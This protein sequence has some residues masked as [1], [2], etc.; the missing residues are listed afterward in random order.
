MRRL[1]TLTFRL[2][3]A[4]INVDQHAPLYATLWRSHRRYVMWDSNEVS[5]L[6]ILY[7]MMNIALAPLFVVLPILIVLPFGAY[8]AGEVAAQIEQEQRQNRLD[9]LA[10]LPLGRLHTHYT[11]SVLS[12]RRTG[13]YSRIEDALGMTA[14]ITGIMGFMLSV[15]VFIAFAEA[16]TLLANSTLQLINM[17]VTILGFLGGVYIQQIQSVVLAQLIG[18]IVPVVADFSV[19]ARV[20]AIVSYLSLQVALYIA[21][22]V[23]WLAVFP[24]ILRLPAL[25]MA[26]STVVT[27][28]LLLTADELILRGLWERLQTDLNAAPEASPL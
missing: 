11:L 9:L 17:L 2:W 28:G 5:G 18:L 19:G 12:I 4:L 3:D 7:L 6:S 24:A 15:G 21:A 16:E 20:A 26:A 27:G 8:W 1:L 14:L 10:V 23:L 13:I 22:G 25:N